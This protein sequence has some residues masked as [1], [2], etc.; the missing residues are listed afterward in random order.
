MDRGLGRSND[1]GCN[2]RTELYTMQSC[3]VLLRVDKL[4]T[5]SH[6]LDE[7]STHDSRLIP[8]RAQSGVHSVFDVKRISVGWVSR[9]TCVVPATLHDMENLNRCGMNV[10]IYDAKFP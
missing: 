3:T 5:G 8:C 10:L 2:G 7:R 9:K 1:G 4:K 6:D